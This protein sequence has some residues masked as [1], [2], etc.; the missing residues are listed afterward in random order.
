MKLVLLALAIL[1][2]GSLGSEYDL[3][4]VRSDIPPDWIV[5]QAYSHKS[6]IPIVTTLPE[7][8]D[9]DVKAQLLGYREAGFERVVIIGGEKAISLEIQ[10]ELEVMG[11]ATHRIS[12]ADRHG[13]SARVAVELYPGVRECVLVNGEVFEGMLTAQRIASETGLPILFIKSDEVPVSV[14]DAMRSL[15]VE[16]VILI[17][18][19][20]TE[21]VKDYL[22]GRYEIRPVR[23]GGVSE[24]YDIP[25]EVLYLAAGFILGIAVALGGT[26]LKRKEKVSFTL[27]TE[28]EE[29]VVRAIME[30]GGEIMQDQLPEK[31]RFSR[32]KVSRVVSGLQERKILSKEPHGRTQKIRIEKEFRE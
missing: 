11:F 10:R 29:K 5:A 30:S 19:G 2:V 17:D 4:L 13:T 22:A 18:Y 15:G 6:G 12:E 24:R 25:G 1:T 26:K 23:K 21:E 8:M 28:D 20:V 16:R 14:S 7:Q 27:L 9:E 32:P 3:I 31:V